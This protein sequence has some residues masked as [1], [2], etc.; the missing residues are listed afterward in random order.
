MKTHISSFTYQFKK[1]VQMLKQMSIEIP[2]DVYYRMSIGTIN[3][4]DRIA[5]QLIYNKEYI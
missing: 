2:G 1:K 5:K 3:D 4:L